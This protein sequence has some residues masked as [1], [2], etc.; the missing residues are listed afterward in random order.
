VRARRQGKG[1]GG[2][3]GHEPRSRV[4]LREVQVHDL[5]LE[6]RTQHQIAAALGISQPAVS[7]ILRRV[8][9]RLLADVAYKA[10]RQRARQTLRLEYVYG[11]AIQAWQDSKQEGLRRRQR[12]T[13]HDGGTGSTVAELIS[14]AR[15]GDPRYLDEAR[16]ALSDLRKVWGIDAP[17][18]VSVDATSHFAS[19]T[20]EALELELSRHLRL[21]R[22]SSPVIDVTPAIAETQEGGHD[23]KN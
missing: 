23:E 16:K 18:R 13:E 9:E 11:Q 12:K 2:K 7:K 4:R 8:E 5:V 20:D 21:V 10:E 1:R 22:P 17:E 6:G 19:M 14:E 15:H 3:G